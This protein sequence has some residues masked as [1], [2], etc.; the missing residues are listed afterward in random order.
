MIFKTQAIL[1]SICLLIGCNYEI[2]ANNPNDN[3]CECPELYP[4][5]STYRLKQNNSNFKNVKICSSEKIILEKVYYNAPPFRIINCLYPENYIEIDSTFSFTI[6]ETVSSL[7]ILKGASLLDCRTLKFNSISTMNFNFEDL[8]IISHNG[9]VL[10][11]REFIYEYV[12]LEKHEKEELKT[13]YERNYDRLLKDD[14]FKYSFYSEIKVLFLLALNDD[15]E[16]QNIL[17]NLD[18]HY[19]KQYYEQLYPTKMEYPDLE[20]VSNI[21][22]IKN[23]TYVINLYINAINNR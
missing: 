14:E 10:V 22:V 11:K 5:E 16:S 23:T 12:L 17:L 15:E 13:R 4:I 8:Q 6:N 20:S 3:E 7:S 19:P 9:Q 18:Q 2:K 1:L 21:D